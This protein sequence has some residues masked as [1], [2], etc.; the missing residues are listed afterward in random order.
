MFKEAVR[1]CYMCSLLLKRCVLI[2]IAAVD[3]GLLSPPR[4]GSVRGSLTVFP[5]VIDFACDRGFTLE[6]S[7]SRWCQANAT[8]SGKTASC[9][10]NN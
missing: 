6:G 1:S 7:P 3:C 4:N 5:N 10:G 9:K 8:W 2:P